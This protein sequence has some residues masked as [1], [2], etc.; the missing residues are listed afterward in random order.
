LAPD[1]ERS[2]AEAGTQPASE[3]D[4]T[5]ATPA[6]ADDLGTLSHSLSAAP[7]E[8]ALPSIS[9]ESERDLDDGEAD[10]SALAAG[11]RVVGSAPETSA[12]VRNPAAATPARARAGWALPLLIGLGLGLGSAA[13]F[14]AISGA[15]KFQGQDAAGSVQRVAEGRSSTPA[16]A[17]AD[18]PQALVASA[19]ASASETTAHNA[20]LTP[21]TSAPP[22]SSAPPSPNSRSLAAPQTLKRGATATEA[23]PTRASAAPSAASS[24]GPPPQEPRAGGP[25]PSGGSMDELL[26][27][28]LA[29]AGERKLAHERQQAALSQTTLPAVPSRDDV[30]RSMSV[31]L[32]A[33]RGCTAGKSGLATATIVVRNDGQ[34]ANVAVDGFPFA[35]NS[36]GRCME[37]VIRRARFPAFA[38]ATF[39][40][41]FPFS[42]Q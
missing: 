23:A 8:D 41:K 18:S 6:D 26:D 21:Q 17:P 27:Q 34:V 25:P 7:H 19:S 31:L 1:D 11:R 14:F 4:A 32:P 37:G 12:A 36:S 9:R 28:A 13:A 20:A 24:L 29:P 38:Q 42:I 2:K 30:S 3:R 15:G 35:G 10:L 39:R 22:A 5:P 40:V 33:I 16:K